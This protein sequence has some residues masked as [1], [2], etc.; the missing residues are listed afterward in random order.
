MGRG[1]CGS[2]FEPR[3]NA[4]RRGVRA[5]LSHVVLDGIALGRY[6]RIVV[7]DADLSHPPERIPKT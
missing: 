3:N 2:V 4:V 1:R 6:D 7:M 5:D